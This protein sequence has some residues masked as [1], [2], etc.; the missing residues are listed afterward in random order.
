V[1]L[2]D[3]LTPWTLA[4][5]GDL[6]LQSGNEEKATLLA[7][8]PILVKGHVSVTGKARSEAR[9]SLEGSISIN[10]LT[11]IFELAGGTAG[12]GFPPSAPNTIA[13][14]TVSG[15][16]GLS[17]GPGT[18][19]TGYGLITAPIDF[20][21]GWVIAQGG[22]LYLERPVGNGPIGTLGEDAVLEI[23]DGGM[24]PSVFL[25]GG[26]LRGRLL[27]S[28][29]VNGHGLISAPFTGI[30]GLLAEE[31]RLIVKNGQHSDLR[32]GNYGA[33]NGVLELW[34]DA[35]VIF[36]HFFHVDQGTIELHGF[37]ATLA[38]DS[39]FDISEGSV[40]TDD[41]LILSGEVMVLPG[42]SRVEATGSGSLVL[43]PGCDLTLLGNLTLTAP[44]VTMGANLSV[45]G[46]GTLITGANSTAILSTLK[47][48]TAFENRGTLRFAGASGGRLEP[49]SFRQTAAGTLTVRLGANE[50]TS[51]KLSVRG[52]A[53]IA[54]TLAL[55]WQ[56]GTVPAVGQAWEVVVASA[57]VS[58][59]FDSVIEPAVMPAGLS[60]RVS[61]LTNQVYV[62]VVPAT[63]YETW[64]RSFAAL[65]NS[66]DRLSA[67]DPDR[68]GLPNFLEFALAGNPA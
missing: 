24:L 53:G 27:T 28:L 59:H 57:G 33:R 7:G 37:E 45:T 46:E 34:D 54:G 4:P 3:F 42:E 41:M 13:G 40:T 65:T 49:L 14:G 52:A 60:L 16:G 22:R 29:H 21:G 17:V 2:D 44:Q 39:V 9:V 50:L 68:D 58:G 31:G 15:P 66:A 38:A 51:D 67:A 55:E 61:T 56:P 10:S 20:F 48:E 62:L 19:L 30:A 6:L 32:P 64:V 43:S 35:P 63:P 5:E 8:N 26:E 1:E 18:A 25:L 36:P 11:G 47:P 23:G 12:S